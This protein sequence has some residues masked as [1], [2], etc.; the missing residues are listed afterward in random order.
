MGL[1]AYVRKMDALGGRGVKTGIQADAGRDPD[2]DADL[3]QIAII[4]EFGLGVTAR[5]FVRDFFEKNQQVLAQAMERVAAAVASGKVSNVEQALDMLGQ[6]VEKHQKAH[7]QQSAKWAEPNKPS[8]VKRKKSS[9]PLI[10]HGLM[11][12]AIRYQKTSK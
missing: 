8:T 1:N 4:N 9:T 6:F 10:D 11:L 7:V 2:S 5:P 3:L 12:G